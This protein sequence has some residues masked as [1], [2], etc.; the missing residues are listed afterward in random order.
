LIG[1]AQK[2]MVGGVSNADSGFQHQSLRIDP[3]VI[4]VGEAPTII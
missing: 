3:P 2:R 1:F 4:A